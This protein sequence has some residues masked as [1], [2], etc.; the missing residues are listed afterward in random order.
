M[1]MGIGNREPVQK[2]SQLS[3]QAAD[4][5]FFPGRGGKPFRAKA[6]CSD[7]PFQRSCLTDAIEFRLE[8]FWSGTTETERR[9]M[10][11][12]H[13][14]RSLVSLL[15]PEPDPNERVVYLK[16]FTSEDSHAWMDT[17][18]PPVEELLAIELVG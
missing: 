3:P 5:I 2:C 6:F 12:Y 7:C 17:V 11:Q 14:I 15:P 18:E 16:V 13:F 10:E 8:G 4:A 1:S 9:A